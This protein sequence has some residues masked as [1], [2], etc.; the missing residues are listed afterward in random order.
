[1]RTAF[2]V[3]NLPKCRRLTAA[4]E[5]ALAPLLIFE[6]QSQPNAEAH[7]QQALVML[8]VLDGELILLAYHMLGLAQLAP[9]DQRDA[10]VEFAACLQERIAQS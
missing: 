10:V 1:M 6:S 5:T 2:H 4:I 9:L 3:P 8:L 7:A